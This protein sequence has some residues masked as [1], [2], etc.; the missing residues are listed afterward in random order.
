MQIISSKGVCILD[1]TFSWN[2]KLPDFWEE[3]SGHPFCAALVFWDIKGENGKKIG[4][5]FQQENDCA[6]LFIVQT[7]P[8]IIFNI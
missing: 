6:Q 4:L 5:Y 1:F 3:F 7:F 2:Y 8:K